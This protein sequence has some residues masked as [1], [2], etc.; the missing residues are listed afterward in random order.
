VNAYALTQE[1]AALTLLQ[2]AENARKKSSE[3]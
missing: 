3:K 1:S 2:A